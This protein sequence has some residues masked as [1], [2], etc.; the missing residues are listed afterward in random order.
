MS[1]L[2]RCQEALGRPL[3]KATHLEL[4]A[5]LDRHRLHPRTRYAYISHLAAEALLDDLFACLP[6]P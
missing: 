1:I 2:T 4:A 6:T 5:W 3:V